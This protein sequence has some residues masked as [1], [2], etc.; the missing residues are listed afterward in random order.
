ME[1]IYRII[2]Y[3]AEQYLKSGDTYDR[4]RG[5]VRL[6]QSAKVI[7]HMHLNCML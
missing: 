4:E 2:D 3:Y 1:L 6:T 7:Q 5:V